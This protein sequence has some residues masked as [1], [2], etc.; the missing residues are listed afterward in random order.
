MCNIFTVNKN[1]NYSKAVEGLK[2][3]KKSFDSLVLLFPDVTSEEFIFIKDTWEGLP[4][5]IGKGVKIM[6]LSFGKSVKSLL[7]NYD[8]NAYIV[9][10]KHLNEYECGRVLKGGL[11]NK[12]TGI[13]YLVG[14][15]YRISPNEVHYFCA[16]KDGCLVHSVLSPKPDYSLKKI[17]KSKILSLP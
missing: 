1:D 4:K 6:A 8:S 7:I 11:V 13:V 10:H 2:K 14:D 17:S 16:T 15:E 9:P 12:L 3:V 5:K